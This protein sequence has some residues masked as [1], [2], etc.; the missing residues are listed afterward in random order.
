MGDSWDTTSKVVLRHPHSHTHTHVYIHEYVHTHTHVPAMNF[1]CWYKPGLPTWGIIVMIDCPS[2]RLLI[3]IYTT[4]CYRSIKG[5]RCW[6]MKQPEW[7]LKVL[8][9]VQ[10]LV[11][12]FYMVHD[13][14]YVTPSKWQDYNCGKTFGL[15]LAWEYCAQS[16]CAIFFVRVYFHFSGIG[17]QECDCWYRLCMVNYKELWSQIPE[18]PYHIALPCTVPFR[19]TSFD[20]SHRFILLKCYPCNRHMAICMVSI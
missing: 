15:C 20:L 4:D 12:K 6:H 16:R 18:W 7:V 17:S 5:A 1:Y 9:L 2:R 10:K 3:Y 8:L 13:S 11:S 19:S 14:L